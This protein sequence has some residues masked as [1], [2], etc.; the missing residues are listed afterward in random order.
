MTLFFSFIVWLKKMKILITAPSLDETVNV[1]GIS[2]LV[3]EIINN[4]REEFSHFTAGRKDG[5][6]AGIGWIFN[7]IALPVQFLREI[8][9]EKPDL[10]HINTAFVP[11]SIMR[12][13]SFVFVSRFANT[14]VLLHPNGGRFLIEDFKNKSLEKIAAKMLR[15]A[16]KILVLSDIEKENLTRRWQDLDIEILPNAISIDE[17]LSAKDIPQRKTILFLGRIHESKGLHEIIEACKTLVKEKFEF[18]FRCFGTGPEQDFFVGELQKILGKNFY[19]GG[20]IAGEEKRKELVKAD[21]FLLPSRYG[22]GLP[23]AMLEAMA[24]RCVPVVADV[25]SVRAVIKNGENGFLVEPYSAEQT[26]ENLRN[27]LSDKVDWKFLSENA[28]QTVK[29]NYSIADYVEKLSEI[30]RKTI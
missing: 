29:D 4:S 6:K 12:D 11:L 14:P 28:R 13:A 18:D 23:L 2:T 24:A 15:S 27:L 8:R 16:S 21:I 5:E 7:Q 1:S 25:A 20:V 30:Y 3:R 26:T 19:Y 9:R 10:V 22:E 17:T